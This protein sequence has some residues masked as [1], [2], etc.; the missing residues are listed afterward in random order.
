MKDQILKIAKVKSEKEFY[1]KYPTE[2]AFMAKHGKTLQ[3]AAM[4]TSMVNKQL[5]QLTDWTNPPMAQYGGNWANAGIP[6]LSTATYDASTGLVNNAS[7]VV[8]KSDTAALG[9]ADK[10]PGAGGFDMAGAAMAGLGALPKII[11]GIQAIGEQK[12]KI[13][14]AEQSA[15]ISDVVAQAA[16]SRQAGVQKHNFVRPEDS[17][18]TGA[19]PLGS[20]TNYLAAN[21]TEIQN[22]YTPGTLYSDLGYEPLNDSNLKQYAEGGWMNPEYNPQVIAKFGEYD[23]KDL[24]KPPH[25]A[26]MLRAGGHL[27]EYTPP[28]ARAMSTERMAFGGSLQVGPEGEAELVGYNPISAQNG[29]S[30]ET[31]IFKGPSHDNDGIDVNYAGNPVEVEGG[32]TVYEDGGSLESPGTSA[33]VLGNLHIGKIGKALLGDVD[34]KLTKGVDLDKMK[35]KH[36]GNNIAKAEGKVNKSEEK[37]LQLINNADASAFGQLEMNSG[38]AALLGAKMN[39]KRFDDLKSDIANLQQSYHETAAE[40]GYDDKT[41]EFLEDLKK[42]KLKEAAF[43]AKLETAQFGRTF[44]VN[45]AMYDYSP[46]TKSAPTQ[47]ASTINKKGAVQHKAGKAKTETVDNTLKKL[48]YDPSTDS[49]V[50]PYTQSPVAPTTGKDIVNKI[51]ANAYRGLPNEANVNVPYSPDYQAPT[52]GQA[53]S[54]LATPAKTTSVTPDNVSDDGFNWKDVASA[55]FSQ[56][57]PFLKPTNKLTLDPSEYAGEMLALA[58]NQLEPVNAQTYRPRLKEDYSVSLQDQLNEVDQQARAAQRMAGNNVAAQAQIAAQAAEQKNKIRG[59]QLRMNQAIKMGTYNEN[60]GTLNQAQLQNL[61]TYAVQQDLMSKA[62]SAT[63]AQAFGAI[64]S[65][66]DKFAKNKQENLLLAIDQQRYNYRFTPSGVAYNV[67]DPYQFNASRA[68]GSPKAAPQFAPGVEPLYDASG[69]IID[70]RKKAV[71]SRNGSIV[72]ALKNI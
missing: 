42:G 71:Q 24:L 69:N 40:H 46:V 51:M 31:R 56:I 15:K 49:V 34:K 67:N 72:K 61:Q 26:D 2:E 41:P 32:E 20:G 29:G 59:E 8:S 11:G 39:Y 1:K 25:D 17:L 44:G 38:H 48:P 13:R 3:K 66:A 33:I 58:T 43:G 18:L 12:K 14:K 55:A 57:S 65:M 68:G 7:G 6:G 21:G 19:M 63:K 9:F 23:V 30:G 27:K 22:T 52:G 36:L 16:E 10:A 70:T 37:G 64:Q 4:G 28:S 54:A 50:I 5:T 60:I 53:A 45:D 62:K 35:F 47:F